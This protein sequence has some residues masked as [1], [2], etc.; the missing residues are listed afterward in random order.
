[1]KDTLKI[2]TLAIAAI[3]F[4]GCVIAFFLKSPAAAP[5]FVGSLMF[6]GLGGLMAVDRLF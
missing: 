4:V 3:L 6:A 2:I 5:C 1:V